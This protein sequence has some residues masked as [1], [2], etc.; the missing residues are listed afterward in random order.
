[1]RITLLLGIALTSAT[2]CAGDKDDD[3]IHVTCDALDSEGVDDRLDDIVSNNP[4]VLNLDGH[5]LAAT[6]NQ[7]SGDAWSARFAPSTDEGAAANYYIQLFFLPI[8]AD[9]TL[10]AYVNDAALLNPQ[11]VDVPAGSFCGHIDQNEDDPTADDV[12]YRILGGSIDLTVED[13]DAGLRIEGPVEWAFG[14]IDTSG[15]RPQ[16]NS[17]S[18]RLNGN[19]Q[20]TIAD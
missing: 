12:D 6:Y 16:A 15:P 17:A 3:P 11:C 10:E 7:K 5:C 18:V 13:T 4:E 8:D 20:L 1:M 19:I 14:T 2:G 9:T